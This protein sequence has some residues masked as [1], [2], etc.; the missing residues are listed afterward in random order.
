MN[1][2][3]TLMPRRAIVIFAAAVLAIAA[4]IASVA[5]FNQQARHSGASGVAL[6]GGPFTL[7]DQDG[8]R[9]TEKDFL[10]RHMLAFFGYTYCPD[11]CPTEL[12]VMMA[13][14]DTLGPM[15]EKIQPVF[16]SIDPDR[17]TPDVLKAYVENFG[18]RLMGL[19]GTPEE[20]ATVAKAYRVHYAKAANA[21]S[22]E[23]YLMDHTSIIY[24]M[25]PDGR[26]VQHFAYTT[27]AAKLGRELKAA[28]TVSP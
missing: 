12:Q 25:G 27:D 28:V 3:T 9:V 24:L 23:S 18:P 7:T 15:A 14:L 21:A 17:D 6:V 8:R 22:P 16:I 20:I 5:M 1:E 10:G 2:R 26:F 13:A 19:T 11:I 4:A